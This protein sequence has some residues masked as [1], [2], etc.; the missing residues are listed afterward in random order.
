MSRWKVNKAYGIWYA[1]EHGWK[2]Y[3]GFPTWAEAMAYAD[4][5]SRLAP[6]ITIEDPSGAF[7]DLTATNK[8]EYIHLKSGGDT[9]NLAPHEWRPLAGF[10]LDVANLVEEA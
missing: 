9:F 6:D 10:L 1:I 3:Q 2:R 4:R 5:Y 7:C 8:R